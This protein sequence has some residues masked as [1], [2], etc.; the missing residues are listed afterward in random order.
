[1]LKVRRND[2]E[3]FQYDAAASDSRMHG[4]VV[5]SIFSSCCGTRNRLSFLPRVILKKENNIWSEIVNE[6]KDFF[7]DKPVSLLSVNR[8]WTDKGVHILSKY[9][10]S[11][12]C[13]VRDG[14]IV[15][16]L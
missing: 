1:M 3:M 5:F 13:C 15:F 12:L 2:R 7:Y 8:Q 6:G 11:G 14:S 10:P 4:A 9:L 16:V